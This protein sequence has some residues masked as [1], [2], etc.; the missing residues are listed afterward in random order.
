MPSCNSKSQKR[1][2]SQ[3]KNGGRR[4]K[5][6]LKN[7]RRRKSR[8]VMMGGENYREVEDVKTLFKDKPELQK[9]L[10]QA[11][12]YDNLKD[13]MKIYSTGSFN[14]GLIASEIRKRNSTGYDALIDY[15]RTK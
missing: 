3:S 6:T 15:L 1:P 12:G 7:V 2:Q 9:D 5:R 10:F 11:L 8:K 13:I 14:T 4:K